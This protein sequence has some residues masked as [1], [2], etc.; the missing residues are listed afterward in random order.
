MLTNLVLLVD[1][2][3]YAPSGS[4]ILGGY[5]SLEL[6]R[7]LRTQ[8]QALPLGANIKLICSQLLPLPQ[9]LGLH[10][11]RPESTGR[12]KRPMDPAGM[13]RGLHRPVGDRIMGRQT[14]SHNLPSSDPNACTAIAMSTAWWQHWQHCEIRRYLDSETPGRHGFYTDGGAGK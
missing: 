12:R 2:A 5:N 10:A 8:V 6:E 11:A 13:A 1:L 7:Q 14:D 3:D 4:R 9:R